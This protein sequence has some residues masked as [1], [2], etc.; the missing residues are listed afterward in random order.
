MPTSFDEPIQPTPVDEMKKCP[1]CAERI[2]TE[3][4]KCRY[5]GEFLAG[6]K[7]LSGLTSGGKWYHS[8]W[9]I[10]VAFMMLGP[11]ALPLVWTNPRY[12]LTIKAIVTVGML[13]LTILL[14]Y[15]MVGMY[16][17]LINMIQSLA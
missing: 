14:C 10:I 1:F 7:P 4:I 6:R 15:V 17:Y 9:T 12:S 3:A 13:V 16:R 8:T 5:C 11:L 2:Q